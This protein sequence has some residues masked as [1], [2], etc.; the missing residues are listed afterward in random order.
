MQII[1]A[2]AAAPA[3]TTK[4]MEYKAGEGMQEC[5]KG[6]DCKVLEAEEDGRE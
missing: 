4:D 6:G 5:D 3:P 1:C 2:T